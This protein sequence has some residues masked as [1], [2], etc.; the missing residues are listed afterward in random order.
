[1]KIEASLSAMQAMFYDLMIKQTRWIVSMMLV[2]VGV[3]FTA[4]R[5][6]H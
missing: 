5:Y 2:L 6:I 3:T 4:A 1:M